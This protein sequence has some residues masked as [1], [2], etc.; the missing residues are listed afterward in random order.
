MP[1]LGFEYR[2]Q[3]LY[4][5]DVPLDDLARDLRTPC[6]VYSAGPI[7]ANYRALL[8]CAPRAPTRFTT[9]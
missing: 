4:C 9:P 1:R 3:R 6:Y 2:Q 5:E 7:V 8:P